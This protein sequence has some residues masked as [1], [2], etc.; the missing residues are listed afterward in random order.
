MPNFG[1][2]KTRVSKRVGLSTTA[3]GND[4][5]LLGE[6]LND[7]VRKFLVETKVNVDRSAITVSAE[8]DDSE[9]SSNVLQLVAI[10]ITGTSGESL[11]PQRVDP[12]EILWHRRVTP[13]SGITTRKYALVGDNLFMWY[14]SLASGAVVTVYYVPKPTEM[15]DAS[16]DP[17]NSTYG[18][19]PIQY[20]D[21]LEEYAT[22]KML[23][24]DDSPKRVAQT[25]QRYMRMMVEARRAIRGQGGQSLGKIPRIGGAPPYP[26]SSP[27]T[28]TGW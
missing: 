1:A 23:D 6:Y 14:P 28:D 2:L 19:I 22:W 10:E 26:L 13:S 24:Y 21:V 25:E 11:V 12:E 9:M 16:H 4:D 8:T 7:A 15:S 5:V 17:S 20:H 3:S 18:G 27:S